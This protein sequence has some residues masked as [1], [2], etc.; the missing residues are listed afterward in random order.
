MNFFKWFYQAVLALGLTMILSACG[1][2]KAEEAKAHVF[3]I[4]GRNVGNV[5]VDE[6]GVKF[7]GP[8]FWHK[9]GYLE[10]DGLKLYSDLLP[11]NSPKNAEVF[12]EKGGRKYQRIIEVPELSMELVDKVANST[13]VVNGFEHKGSLILRFEIDPETETARAIWT[14]VLFPARGQ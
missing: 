2:T 10:A 13:K 5:E 4:A 9:W 3:L 6:A 12:W 14:D 1:G 11:R 8:K 7:S